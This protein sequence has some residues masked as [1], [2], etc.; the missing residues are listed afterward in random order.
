MESAKVLSRCGDERFAC[1]L[2]VEQ[3]NEFGLVERDGRNQ[4]RRYD[5]QRRDEREHVGRQ[6]G[7]RWFD[8]GWRHERWYDRQRRYNRQRRD[9]G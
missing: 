2:R 5:R 9:R 8:D 6:H 4:P 3:R 1:G 7:D